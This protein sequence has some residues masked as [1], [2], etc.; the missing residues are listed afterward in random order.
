M[1]IEKQIL[2]LNERIAFRFEIFWEWN[3]KNHTIKQWFL[4]GSAQ[5]TTRYREIKCFWPSFWI[6]FFGLVIGVGF[7]Y[8][9]NQ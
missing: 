4:S 8:A 7:Y 6:R 3:R 9:N 1:N 2:P 5:L